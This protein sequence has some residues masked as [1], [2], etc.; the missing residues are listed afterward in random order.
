M[1]AGCS[2]A[3]VDVDIFTSPFTIVTETSNFNNFLKR[4]MQSFRYS[5]AAQRITGNSLKLWLQEKL[6]EQNKKNQQKSSYQ[7]AADESTAKGA[8]NAKRRSIL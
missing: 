6:Q 4:R 8:K 3:I 2:L 5:K 1:S 7:F